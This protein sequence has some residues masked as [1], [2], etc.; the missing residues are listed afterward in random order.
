VPKSG[1]ALVVEWG[2]LLRDLERL[3]AA[4][5]YTPR[6]VVDRVS[7]AVSGASSPTVLDPA[8]GSLASLARAG[9]IG[10]SKWRETPYQ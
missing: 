2:R 3:S 1:K 6:D 8:C 7:A 10:G 4:N 9:W 5:S